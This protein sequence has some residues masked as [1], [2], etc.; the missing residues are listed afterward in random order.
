ME[1][2]HR[3]AGPPSAHAQVFRGD[4]RASIERHSTFGVHGGSPYIPLP[5]GMG[6]GAELLG[7]GRVARGNT[8]CPLMLTCMYVCVRERYRS[9]PLR[10]FCAA[11]F[12]GCWDAGLWRRSRCGKGETK[13]AKEGRDKDR[14]AHS[15]HTRWR[16]MMRQVM[17]LHH[18]TDEP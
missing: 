17:N 10:R 16:R 12:G 3:V 13:M 5:P 7:I 14:D 2:G 1:G 9:R 15:L 8:R 4:H 18:K 6:G 11:M